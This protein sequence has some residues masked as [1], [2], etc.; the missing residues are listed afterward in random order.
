[1]EVWLGFAFERFCL[2]HAGYLAEIMGFKDEML[3]PSPYFKRGEPGFQVDLVYKRADRVIVACEI[4][5]CN[6][7]I[8][9]KI[10]PEMEKKCTAMVIPRGYTLE[11]TLISLYGPD[12][13]LKSSCYFN[14][15]ITVENII[16]ENR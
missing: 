4:K 8:S 10:I 2:K 14:H 5:Y 12:D 6:A 15:Y 16:A 7:K 13:A 3:L 1:M 9:T 11:R